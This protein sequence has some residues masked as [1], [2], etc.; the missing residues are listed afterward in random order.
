M[1]LAEVIVRRGV[2]E[3]EKPFGILSSNIITSLQ[4]L[5]TGK[6]HNHHH[7]FCASSPRPCHTLMVPNKKALSLKQNP[8]TSHHHTPILRILRIRLLGIPRRRIRLLQPRR[9]PRLRTPRMMPGTQSPLP[10]QRPLHGIPKPNLV[11]ALRSHRRPASANLAFAAQA[12]RR[13]AACRSPAGIRRVGG[14]GVGRGGGAC[15][16]EGG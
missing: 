1:G 4:R 15:L 2:K 16:R 10:N 11:R 8:N 5:W 13:A 3:H 9:R 6:K 12:V 7:S 14:E